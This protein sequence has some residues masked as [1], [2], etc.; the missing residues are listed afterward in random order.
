L[1]QTPK[2]SDVYLQLTEAQPSRPTPSAPSEQDEPTPPEELHIP[3][4]AAQHLHCTLLA[5]LQLLLLLLLLLEA[6]HQAQ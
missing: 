5:C 4:T 1:V 2:S 3:P 6:L